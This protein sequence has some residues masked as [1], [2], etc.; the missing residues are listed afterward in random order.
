MPNSTLLQDLRYGLRALLRAPTVTLTALVALALGIGG[1][2]A[3]FSVV[4]AVLLAPL[5]LG[6][7]DRLLAILHHPAPPA[8]RAN[9]A[10]PRPSRRSRQL[11]RLEASRH[12]LLPD[13]RC[14]VL[15]ANRDWRWRAGKNAGTPHNDGGPGS[16]RSSARAWP[17]RCA[18]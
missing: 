14:G 4:N 3:I 9:P 6:N 1:T 5:P 2:S 17:P 7:P 15:D 16:L 10:P 11:P 8:A 13:G 18:R 12:F